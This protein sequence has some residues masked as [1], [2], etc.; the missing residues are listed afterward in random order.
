[1]ARSSTSFVAPG[2]EGGRE[3]ERKYCSYCCW[4]D[5]DYTTTPVILQ[6]LTSSCTNS[7]MV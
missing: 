5:D 2:P 3:R 4:Y 1:M 6:L 7:V